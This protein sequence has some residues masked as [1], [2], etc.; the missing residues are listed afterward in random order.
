LAGQLS[1]VEQAS[2][3]LIAGFLRGRPGWRLAVDPYVGSGT[4]TRAHLRARVVLRRSGLR[5]RATLLASLAR[6]LTVEVQGEVVTVD[7]AGQRVDTRSG[8]EGYVEVHVAA[9]LTPGWH[10]VTWTVDGTTTTGALLV[11]N[12]RATVGVVSDIDDTVIH[13]GITRM[14]EAVRNTLLVAAEDRLPFPEPRSSTSSSWLATR[15][16]R[17][18]S[19]CPP[20]PGT[21]MG[22]WSSSSPSMDSRLDLW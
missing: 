13:T 22:R 18:C 17:R 8:H 19:T 3:D 14:Y 10:E 15:A 6:Y 2:D 12:P 21:C 5:R 20:E 9:P 16:L 1:R 11:V 7:V 4:T